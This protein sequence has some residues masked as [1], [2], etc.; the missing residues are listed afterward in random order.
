MATTLCTFYKRL[1]NGVYELNQHLFVIKKY[2]GCYEDFH[3]IIV[4]TR[5]AEAAN[6]CGSGSLGCFKIAPLSN[7]LTAQQISDGVLAAD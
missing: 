3:I 1:G 4:V 7:F 6:F 2:H 5:D